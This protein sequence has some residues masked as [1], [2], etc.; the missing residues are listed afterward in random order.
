ME[1]VIYY[2]RLGTFPYNVEIGNMVMNNI[3]VF[4]YRVWGY[5]GNIFKLTSLTVV[6]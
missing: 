4:V 5:S 2:F 1:N 3:T 6:E